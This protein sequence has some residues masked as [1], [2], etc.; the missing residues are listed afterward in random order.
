M[1]SITGRKELCAVTFDEHVAGL[2]RGQFEG[3]VVAGVD[4]CGLHQQVVDVLIIDLSKGDP[5]GE[6]VALAV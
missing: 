6:A 3:G 5:D 2:V 1:Y 4:G